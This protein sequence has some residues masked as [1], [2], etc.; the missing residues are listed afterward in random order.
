MSEIVVYTDP[1]EQ[2]SSVN[3][4]IREVVGNGIPFIPTHLQLSLTP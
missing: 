4:T 3:E 1:F 2:L